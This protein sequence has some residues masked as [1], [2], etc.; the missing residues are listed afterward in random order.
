MDKK[1]RGAAPPVRTTLCAGS[2]ASRAGAMFF[3]GIT[4]FGIGLK[5]PTEA[6]GEKTN[7]SR[8]CLTKKKKKKV[9]AAKEVFHL[10][11]TLPL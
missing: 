2:R 9:E 4:E 11:L 5:D 8:S 7:A 10:L 1:P 3:L 6:S